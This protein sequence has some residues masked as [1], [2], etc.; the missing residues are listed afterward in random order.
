MAPP[1]RSKVPKGRI[2]ARYDPKVAALTDP[3]AILLHLSRE[4][5]FQLRVAA[6]KGEPCRLDGYVARHLVERKLLFR[7]P[8]GKKSLYSLTFLGESVVEL[9]NERNIVTAGKVNL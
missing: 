6:R 1:F 7:I 4:A 5:L 9:A 2:I 3:D 8:D